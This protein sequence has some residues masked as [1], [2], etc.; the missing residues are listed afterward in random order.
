MLAATT[1]AT[2]ATATTAMTFRRTCIPRV[3]RAFDV[4]A[5]SCSAR[6]AIDSPAIAP[7]DSGAS[8]LV[9]VGHLDHR[10]VLDREARGF[11]WLDGAR[12]VLVTTTESNARY[13]DAAS[14]VSWRDPS[15]SGA[16]RKAN[17]DRERYDTIACTMNATPP[18][19][20]F[21][22]IPSPTPAVGAPTIPSSLT[23]PLP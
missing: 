20:L 3:W 22:S 14:T 1:A 6:P 13:E 12:F 4:D 7:A 18:S 2:A 15:A 23:M 21:G 8:S 5:M 19:S 17:G 11:T 9:E 10:I 16:G